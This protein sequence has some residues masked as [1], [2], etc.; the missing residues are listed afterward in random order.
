MAN[1]YSV[2]ELIRGWLNSVEA[3]E[4]PEIPDI[5]LLRELLA[6]IVGKNG[7]PDHTK[8]GSLD[9]A[10]CFGI[11]LYVF[12]NSPEQIVCNAMT[13]DRPSTPFGK[14]KNLM[15]IE[16]DPAPTSGHLGAN[17]TDWRS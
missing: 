4:L 3:H 5:D 11:L 15:G 9:I 10:I 7:R 13:P 12:K 17:I 6:C 14:L 8:A 1:R 16:T 2:F